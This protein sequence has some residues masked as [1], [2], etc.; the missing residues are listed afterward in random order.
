MA[1]RVRTT[2]GLRTLNDPTPEY[3]VASIKDGGLSWTQGPLRLVES[4]QQSSVT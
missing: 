3:P 1:R 2:R 4:D